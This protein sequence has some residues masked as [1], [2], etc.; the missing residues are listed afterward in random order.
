MTVTRN[1]NGSLT[2]SDFVGGWLESMTYY[3]YTVRE[4][5][6]LFREHLKEIESSFI[7]ES[8]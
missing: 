3:G 4:A 1:L 2:I 6:A 5:K 7:V 8:T